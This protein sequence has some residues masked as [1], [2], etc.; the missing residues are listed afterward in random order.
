MTNPHQEC[1]PQDQQSRNPGATSLC[2]C[3][4]VCAL[5]TLMEHAIL[6]VKMKSTKTTAVEIEVKVYMEQ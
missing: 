5:E 6:K 4:G 1:T 3:V 2:F